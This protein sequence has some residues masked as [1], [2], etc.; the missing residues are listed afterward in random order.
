M[1]PPDNAKIYETPIGKLWFGED[2]ILYSI[3]KPVP[4]TLENTKETFDM[5]ENLVGNRKVCV[6]ADIAKLQPM[7]K[8]TREYV[9]N[10][11]PKFFKAYAIISTSALG[12]MITNI[13]IT[14]KPSSVPTKFFS[15]EQEAKKWLNQ[16]LHENNSSKA[17]K[18]K[19]MM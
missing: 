18:N 17:I 11:T 14:L 5:V 7:D 2:G 6:L 3:S 13:F 10:I 4:R 15:N 9:A 8:E 12:R 16:F 1:T 19:I